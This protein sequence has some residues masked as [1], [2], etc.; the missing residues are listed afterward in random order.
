[1]N[2]VVNDDHDGNVDDDDYSFHSFVLISVMWD[3][4]VRGTTG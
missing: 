3:E 4:N 1:M 2:E